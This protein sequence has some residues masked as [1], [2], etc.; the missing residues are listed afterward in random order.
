MHPASEL[1]N[2]KPSGSHSLFRTAPPDESRNAQCNQQEILEDAPVSWVE[3]DHSEVQGR[4][5]VMQFFGDKYGNKVRVVQIG[6]EAKGLDGYSMELCGGTHVRS[7]GEIGLFRIMSEAAVAAGTRRI[8]ASSGLVSYE[9]MRSDS[10]LL[11]RMADRV[12]A[13]SPW[14]AIAGLT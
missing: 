14:L 12:N 8:E 2:N 7:T 3:V 13:P 10:A 1:E 5:D 9:Q 11:Q 4:E 6:G